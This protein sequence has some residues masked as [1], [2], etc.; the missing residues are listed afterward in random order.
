MAVLAYIAKGKGWEQQQQN[1]PG[2]IEVGAEA[3]TLP[4]MKNCLPSK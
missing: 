1:L 2:F 4:G 3:N